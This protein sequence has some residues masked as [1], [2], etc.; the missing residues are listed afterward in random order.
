MRQVGLKILEARMQKELSEEFFD[1]IEKTINAP[2]YDSFNAPVTPK[3]GI[4]E[5]KMVQT[6]YIIV[7]TAVPLSCF[8]VGNIKSSTYKLL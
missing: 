6:V 2:T 7:C 5:T 1:G 3:T 8:P 4:I